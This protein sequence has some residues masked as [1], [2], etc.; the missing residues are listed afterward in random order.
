M[1]C[2]GCVLIIAELDG[3]L[4]TKIVC[5]L[6]SI[7][8]SFTHNSKGVQLLF[9]T[10]TSVMDAKLFRRDQIWFIEKDRSHATHLYP[11]TDFS[12]RKN[13]SLEKG[14]LVERYGVIPFINSQ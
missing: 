6:L 11:L 2:K 4:Y 9:T 7:I 1:L 10:D 3:S 8:N 14:Y 12:P 13:E 5:F